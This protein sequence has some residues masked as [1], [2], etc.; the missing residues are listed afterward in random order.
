M[1][2]NYDYCIIKFFLK[3]K[4][5]MSR[6]YS[7]L[8]GEREGCVC[9]CSGLGSRRWTVSSYSDLIFLA[10]VIYPKEIPKKRVKH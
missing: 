2:K 1:G 5:K 10:P 7:Y 6:G 4:M 9:K 3:E 8:H